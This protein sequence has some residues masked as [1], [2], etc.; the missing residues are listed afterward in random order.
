L[1]VRR[2]ETA[3][4]DERGWI[5][6]VLED[7]PIEHVSVILSRKGSVRGNHFHRETYQWVYLLSGSF[8]YVVETDD[9]GRQEGLIE[10][11]DLL[12][13]EPLDRH[14]LETLED[15]TMVVLTRG[16]RGGRNYES[17]TIRLDDPLIPPK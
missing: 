15:A 7:E 8:R 14:A 17:D 4:E 10:A 6:D 3:F 1:I 12:L 16:P 13:T 2:V 9:G 5:K 11:G